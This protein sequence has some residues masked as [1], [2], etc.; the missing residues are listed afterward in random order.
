MKV[1]R[2]ARTLQGLEARERPLAIAVDNGRIV[3]AGETLES[4]GEAVD[5]EGRW[6]LPSFCDCHM[7]L[8]Y[9]AQQRVQ[10]SLPAS[11]SPQ[12]FIDLVRSHPVEPGSWILGSGWRQ[13]QLDQ[14]GSKVLSV[15]DEVDASRPIFL[16]SIDHHRALVNTRAREAL[17]LA[18]PADAAAAV[19]VETEAEQAWKRIPL[20]APDLDGAIQDLHSHG[21]TAIGC[22]DRNDSWELFRSLAA[23]DRLPLWVTH[24]FPWEEFVDPEA[25]EAVTAGEAWSSVGSLR[26]GW[27]KLFLDG[28]LGSRTAWMFEDYDDDP[29]NRGIARI[30]EAEL[31]DGLRRIGAAGKAVAIHAIGDAAVARAATVIRTL[32]ELRGSTEFGND[33]IEHAE[34]MTDATLAELAE[35]RITASVQPCHL[36]AD[37]PAAP[38]RWGDRC[39]GLLP[40]RRLWDAGVPVA[41]GTD[42]PIETVD[43][44]VN[45]RAACDRRDRDGGPAA[46]FQP[47]ERLT[48]GEAFFAATA[49][50]GACNQL[51]S[52]WGTLAVGTSADFQILE[53]EDPRFITD[54]EQSGLQEVFFRGER[55]WQ[56]P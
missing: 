19:L 23:A 29:G 51:E 33:R 55:V 26:R 1:F 3:A 54:R 49:G 8:H 2:N 41:F 18:P 12:A 10:L 43:P 9:A 6:L 47:Q 5:L 50:A 40:L 28:T 31:E 25:D 35:H 42:Y 24:S 15:L 21:I 56:R 52:G 53:C 13:A 46:G 32:R 27:V 11:L 36:L 14:L 34:L 44:W 37:I 39:R 16:W 30:P 7:H 20:P 38:S 17:G 4:R 48:F 22:F 45:I